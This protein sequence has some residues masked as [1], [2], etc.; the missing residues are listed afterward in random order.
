L[1]DF[2]EALYQPKEAHL[3]KYQ[4]V[5][6]PERLDVPDS[7]GTARCQEEVHLEQ[8]DDPATACQEHHPRYREA[9]RREDSAKS[10]EELGDLPTEADHR[11]QSGER[12]IQVRAK[13]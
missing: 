13:H 5:D 2:P 12:G 3:P 9:S 11:V 6:H 1:A 8:L 10:Q 4:E 7:Q